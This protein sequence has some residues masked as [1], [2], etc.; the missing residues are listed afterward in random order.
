MSGWQK[1]TYDL[2]AARCI[3][4]TLS[5]T[6]MSKRERIREHI[7]RF[8]KHEH[9]KQESD[10]SPSSGISVNEALPNELL[11]AIF[12]FNA[13]RSLPAF[14]D[15]LAISHTCH[16]WRDIAIGCPELW[17]SYPFLH[18][19]QDTEFSETLLKRCGDVTLDA[20]WDRVD[21]LGR[22][23]SYHAYHL[24]DMEQQNIHRLRSYCVL[25]S[26]KLLELMQRDGTGISLAPSMQELVLDSGDLFKYHPTGYM[27]VDATTPTLSILRLRSV[28]FDLAT[29]RVDNLHTF[30]LALPSLAIPYT[31]QQWLSFIQGC[32]KLAHL[33]LNLYALPESDEHPST[34]RPSLKHRFTLPF[35]SRLVLAAPLSFCCALLNRFDIPSLRALGLTWPDRE[36][37]GEI[38]RIVSRIM[39]HLMTG[40]AGKSSD[41]RMQV[42]VSD[43]AGKLYIG[44]TPGNVDL[45]PLEDW[46]EYAGE[47]FG[48]AHTHPRDHIQ[49]R[50]KSGAWRLGK[51]L[52]YWTPV[53]RLISTLYIDIPRTDTMDSP[54]VLDFFLSARQDAYI[55]W[56][57]LF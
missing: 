39:V 17:R 25:F 50:I 38:H 11:A 10:E 44:F 7:S 53:A 28:W 37:D 3:R 26:P 4:C 51:M 23:S 31:A 5:P 35:L 33:S 15:V 54:A 43:G 56:D 9:L 47:H 16:L 42:S 48:T 19:I 49:L 20:G 45:P 34:L 6:T 55:L 36:I 41:N 21:N 12:V 29:L 13:G 2:M 40:V 1:Q 27:V 30:D 18:T 32:P 14:K 24:L 57:Y 8:F 46:S 52:P 22:S